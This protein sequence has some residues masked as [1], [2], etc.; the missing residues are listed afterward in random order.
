MVAAILPR[1]KPSGQLASK[2]DS[3]YN[4]TMPTHASPEQLNP[5]DTFKALLDE[6]FDRGEPRR[7]MPGDHR[8]EEEL[9]LAPPEDVELFE[10]LPDR[11]RAIRPKA[12]NIIPVREFHP[13]ELR[14]H[15]LGIVWPKLGK[16]SV[17]TDF[18]IHDDELWRNDASSPESQ[19][20]R[21]HIHTGEGYL[22]NQIVYSGVIGM[23][24][25]ERRPLQLE[26]TETLLAYIPTLTPTGPWPGWER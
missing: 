15:R 23:G 22:V 19:H 12:D 17:L 13:M 10:K 1:P 2:A 24:R 26:E 3:P 18:Y 8:G 14:G 21:H 4:G 5:V 7:Y 16:W 6:Q 25:N 11:I 9:F 20:V